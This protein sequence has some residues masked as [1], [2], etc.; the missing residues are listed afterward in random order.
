MENSSV[1]GWL[2]ALLSYH[3][4]VLFSSLTVTYVLYLNTGEKFFPFV[5]NVK[6][7]FSALP[8]PL[9]F[10]FLKDASLR[11]MAVPAPLVFSLCYVYNVTIAIASAVACAI[12]TQ[13]V[14]PAF[15]GDHAHERTNA[16]YR[17][18]RLGGRGSR[19]RRKKHGGCRHPRHAAE[20]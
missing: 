3:S 9:R 5:I 11:D 10:A 8:S 18:E 15:A 1:V 13:E 4:W 12:N 7:H 14:I 16:D 6:P 2:F 19:Q 17:R 20:Q